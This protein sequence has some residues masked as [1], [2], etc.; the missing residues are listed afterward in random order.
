[1][2]KRVLYVGH[3]MTGSTSRH[4]AEALR[5]LGHEVQLA[6]PY[7]SFSRRLGRRLEGP[8]HYRTG[9][10]LLQKRICAWVEDLMK[11]YEG[12]QPDAVWV[13]GGELL[14]RSALTLLRRFDCPVL[15]YNNDDPTGTRDGRRFDS[16][17]AALPLYDLCVVVRQQNV[18]EF[19][20]LKARNVHRIWMSYDEVVHRPFDDPD[21]IPTKFRSEVAFIGTWMRGERR[22]QFLLSLTQRGI[23]LSIWGDAWDKSPTW[24]QLKQFWR[25][26]SI[27]GR[28]YVAAIQGSK[29]ALG[30]LSKGNRDLHTTRS[31]EIPYSGGLLCAERTA[32][33]LAMYNEGEEVVLWSDA[34]ECAAACHRLLADDDMRERIRTRGALRVRAGKFGNE[35]VVQAV[36][37]RALEMA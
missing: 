14:G 7:E 16:L 22:D 11:E 37:Q 31:V 28:D 8:L 18:R 6:D 36:L 4:R 13:N 27:Y 10:R 5:R 3:A 23:P 26:P 19:E 12:G 17:I 2:K 30:L 35:D 9:Y 34:D 29:L 15:L 33:H 25:G 20:R 32:E 21:E 24:P 1:M